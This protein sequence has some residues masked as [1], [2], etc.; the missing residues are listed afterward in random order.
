MLGESGAE[1]YL[2]PGRIRKCAAWGF[3]E[4]AFVATLKRDGEPVPGSAASNPRCPVVATYLDRRFT[5]QPCSHQVHAA[6]AALLRRQ[7]S[8]RL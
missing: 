4:L 8:P 2:S 1:F 6:D 7:N 5:L 3:H